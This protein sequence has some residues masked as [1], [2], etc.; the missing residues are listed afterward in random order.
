MEEDYDVVAITL[1]VLT[2]MRWITEE[3]LIGKGTCTT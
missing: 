2:M 1:V 3:L